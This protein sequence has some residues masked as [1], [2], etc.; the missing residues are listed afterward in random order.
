[1]GMCTD[2]FQEVY[3]AL[4]SL[5]GS[6]CVQPICQ[7]RTHKECGHLLGI[8]LPWVSLSTLWLH[9]NCP[10]QMYPYFSGQNAAIERKPSWKEVLGESVVGAV[11]LLVNLFSTAPLLPGCCA[12][13]EKEIWN[14]L[15]LDQPESLAYC[16]LM[17]C[18][19]PADIMEQTL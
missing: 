14:V 19:K 11:V 13:A 1:M 17:F 10:I 2:I 15:A 9:A 8:S 4:N 12:P 16:L 6:L 5:S 18:P 3:W 7:T